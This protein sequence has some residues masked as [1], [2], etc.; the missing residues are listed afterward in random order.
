MIY[1]ADPFHDA[2]ETDEKLWEAEIHEEVALI[3]FK[4][5]SLGNIQDV[6]TEQVKSHRYGEQYTLYL[7]SDSHDSIFRF[8][9]ML[10]FQ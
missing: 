1:L 3:V 8:Y 2:N 7:D 9:R 10:N 6:Y 5:A 4:V